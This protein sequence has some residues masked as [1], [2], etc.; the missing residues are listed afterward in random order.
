MDR[1]SIPLK[2][3]P[4]SKYQAV[5][6]AHCDLRPCK[7]VTDSLVGL[8]VESLAFGALPRQFR[9]RADPGKKGCDELTQ[10]QSAEVAAPAK[11]KDG[12][13][14]HLLGALRNSAYYRTPTRSLTAFGRGCAALW[15]WSVNAYP[16]LQQGLLATFQQR[17]AWQTIIDWRFGRRRAPQWAIELLRAALMRRR[18][19]IDHAL[20]LIKKETGD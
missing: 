1:G 20:A 2:W 17:P 6:M 15:P 7:S 10:A 19:E 16:G 12:R 4:T 11:R 3:F 14:N 18:D 8:A 5:D 9:R 13:G